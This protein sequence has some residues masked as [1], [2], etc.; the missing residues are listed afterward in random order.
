MYNANLTRVG[1]QIPLYFVGGSLQY[2]TAD[3]GGA[4]RSIWLSVA[5]TLA[6]GAICPVTGY[7]SD[8]FGRKWVSLFGS[9]LLCV[10]VLIVP[11]VSSMNY[12]IA[13]MALA[14]AG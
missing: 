9:G 12:A 1:S 8:I 13:G 11:L 7:M 3:L 6:L 2:I 5:N 10:G 4:D 14:G